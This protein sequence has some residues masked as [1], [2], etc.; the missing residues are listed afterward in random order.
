M[1]NIVNED[2]LLK[3]TIGDA[4]DPFLD[5]Y[6]KMVRQELDETVQ[7]NYYLKY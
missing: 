3:E 1:S 5:P 4:F 6:I 2:I 7:V